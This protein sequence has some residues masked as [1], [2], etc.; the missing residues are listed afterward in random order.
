[1]SKSHRDNVKAG[2]KRGQI[3]FAKRQRRRRQ[4]SRP[5]CRVCGQHMRH[6]L[7][8]EMCSMCRALFM[9]R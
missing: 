1:M 3:A 8:G 4:R 5:G 6:N 2:R 9:E 7:A